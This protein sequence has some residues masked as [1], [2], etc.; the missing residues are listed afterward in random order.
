M[1]KQKCAEEVRDTMVSMQHLLLKRHSVSDG[2]EPQLFVSV[3]PG[4]HL[5]SI[6]KFTQDLGLQ[7]SAET[8][9]KSVLVLKH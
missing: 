9:K 7:S 5:Q 2:Y 1:E 4:E 6:L 3:E 8:L